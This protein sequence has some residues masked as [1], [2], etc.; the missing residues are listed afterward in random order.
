MARCLALAN[1]VLGFACQAPSETRASEATP[2]PARSDEPITP[3]PR[4]LGTKPR[5]AAL[6]EALF[7][8]T[9]VSGDGKVACSHCHLEDRGMADARS[10]SLLPGR[11]Q[12]AMNSTSMY[13]LG[14]LYKLTWN[15]RFDSL[16]DHLDWLVSSPKIMGSTWASLAD[17]L[18]ADPV[19]VERFQ[20][21]F[22]DGVTLANARAALLEY[23]R[24]LVTP[25]S[26][27][28][29][30]L[31]GE[32]GALDGDARRGYA[33]FKTYG[34]VTC[35]QGVLV[36]AN[37]VERFGVMRDYFA[38]RSEVSEADLGRYNVTRRE[39]DRH[40]FRVPSLRNVALT[41]PYFHDG[42]APDL[43]TAVRIMGAY[44]L[45]LELEPG[46]V[47]LLVRFLESLT[48]EYRGKRL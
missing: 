6:G 26:P 23:E 40:V 15:A 41:A 25:D 28:D 36:G 45:G 42:S 47:R 30:Y 48:G 17:R 24:S 38:D 13:N 4:E 46:D 39:E 11:P 22:D 43:P 21:V 3:L 5:I 14:L 2:P 12:T 44:Q 29:R 35:H 7:E 31:R 8:S 1:A 10:H 32:I 19:W 33:L 34:C 9:I 27:F 18:R 16:E 20:S 37:M